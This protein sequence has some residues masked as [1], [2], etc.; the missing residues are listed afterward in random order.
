VKFNAGKV[1][2]REIDKGNSIKKYVIA[3]H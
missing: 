1:N 3:A 2:K